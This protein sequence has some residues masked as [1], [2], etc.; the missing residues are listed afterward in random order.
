[1]TRRPGLELTKTTTD[2][3]AHYY[4]NLTGNSITSKGNRFRAILN[5]NEFRFIIP[6]APPKRVAGLFR[7]GRRALRLDKSNAVFNHSRDGIIVLYQGK[8]FFFDLQ[9]RLLRMVGQLKQCRN[10]L[11]CGISVTEDSIVFGEYGANPNRDAVPVWRSTDDGR[12]WQV[13]YE[14]PAGSIKHVHGVYCD[15]YSNSLWIPTGDFSGECY[16]FEVRDRNFQSIVRHGDGEQRWRAVNI[17]FD[18]DRIVWAMDSQLQESRLQ[19]FDRATGNLDELRG[20]EGPVW[21]SKRFTDGSAVLQTTV[22]IGDGVKSSYAHVFFSEDLVHW[23]EVA[24][25]RKDL[26]PKRYFKSG[27]IA[28]ADGPQTRDDFVM[29][30]EALRGMDG[31][32]FQARII[33]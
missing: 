2:E 18:P 3:V 16:L 27:V 12:T 24:R 33:S 31:T 11:H 23:T 1:M 5:N 10:V 20:F 25:F 8:I 13:V 21:Y 4:D 26:W 14:F 15:P 19:V 6:L 17:F 22:E 30:G 9:S 7:I 29:F 28:F 32:V